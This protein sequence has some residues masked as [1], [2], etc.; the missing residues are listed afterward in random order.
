[1]G[2]TT[3]CKLVARQTDYVRSERKL[4]MHLVASVYGFEY[5]YFNYYKTT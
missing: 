1:M 5:I 3:K 4:I 2:L